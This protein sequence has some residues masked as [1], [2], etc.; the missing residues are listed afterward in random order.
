MTQNLLLFRSAPCPAVQWF[1]FWNE[2]AGSYGAEVSSTE[3]RLDQDCLT[4]TQR[5]PDDT[6]VGQLDLNGRRLECDRQE[7][8]FPRLG[9]ISLGLFLAERLLIRPS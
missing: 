2:S 3:R 6:S 9:L 5:K 4:D 7:H 1:T 8:S